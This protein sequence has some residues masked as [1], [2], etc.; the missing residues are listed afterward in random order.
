MFVCLIFRVFEIVQQPEMRQ[1]CVDKGVPYQT[2]FLH[3]AR[4]WEQVEAKKEGCVF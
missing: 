2:A 4:V 3:K 1:I